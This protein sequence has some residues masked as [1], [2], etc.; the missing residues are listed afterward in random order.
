[1]RRR[2]LGL[3]DQA[4]LQEKVFQ[5]AEASRF[6]QFARTVLIGEEEKKIRK[7]MFDAIDSPEP[8]DPI[9]AAQAWIELRAVYKLIKRLE[10]LGAEGI[11]AQ[12]A[13][14]SATP[15]AE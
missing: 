1:M 2:A 9:K 5:G 7:R 6:A 12:T 3:D 8:L 15:K 11:A 4:D 10:R 13:L 14:D